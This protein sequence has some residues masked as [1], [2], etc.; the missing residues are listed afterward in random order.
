MEICEPKTDEQWQAYYGLRWRVLRQ[1]C[2]QP[3]GSEKDELEDDAYHLMAVDQDQC[4]GVGRVHFH[5]LGLGQIRYMAVEKD[6][7]GQGIG[8]KILQMLEIYLL[9]N[10]TA[11]V[12]LNARKEAVGFYEKHGYQVV[13]EGPLLFGQIE[14]VKMQKRL[15]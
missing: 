2:D 9:R 3:V 14:H 15:M 12:I 5:H 8:L 13:E 7:R 11:S 10:E 1:M 4:V 6:W